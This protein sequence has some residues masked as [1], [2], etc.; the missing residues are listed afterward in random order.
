M[1][2]TFENPEDLYKA[3]EEYRDFVKSTPKLVQKLAYNQV[4]NIEHELPLT[5]QGFE[6]YVKADLSRYLGAKK[7]TIY[8]HY[9]VISRQIKKEVASDQLQGAIIGI[10]NANI[11][12]RLTGL[13]AKVEAETMRTRIEIENESRRK[14]MN[15]TTPEIIFIKTHE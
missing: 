9:G 4:V 3:F 2:K 6:T 13:H 12:S 1:I 15:F 5:L 14:G 11:V 10:W 8:E 7:G